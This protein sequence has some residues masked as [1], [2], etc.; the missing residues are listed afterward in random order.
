MTND[1]QCSLPLWAVSIIGADW[2]AVRY[3]RA[4]NVGHAI[5]Y[6]KNEDR[7]FYEETWCKVSARVQN[8]AKGFVFGR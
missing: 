3:V 2:T 5:R 4:E 8:E 1:T 6:V 7:K